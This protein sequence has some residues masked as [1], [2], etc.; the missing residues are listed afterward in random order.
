MDFLE[1]VVE[2]LHDILYS[3]VVPVGYKQ[4]AHILLDKY[5]EETGQKIAPVPNT[6]VISTNIFNK[7]I[8]LERAIFDEIERIQ[9]TRKIE[10]IKLLR[11]NVQF[12]GRPVTAHDIQ[13]SATVPIQYIGLKDAKDI[14]DKWNSWASITDTGLQT[15]SIKKGMGYTI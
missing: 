9:A 8:V 1:S 10:A 3:D 13:M 15:V 12:D 7:P 4:Q 11:Q 14:I 2:Y 6:V 5:R